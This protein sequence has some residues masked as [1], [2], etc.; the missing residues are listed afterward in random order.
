MRIGRILKIVL[1]VVPVALV[2]GIAGIVVILSGTDFNQ[3]KP[4]IAEETK[5]AI[6]RDLVIAGDL[7]L[8]ISLSP[9]VAVS[10]LTLSNAVWSERRDM[11]AI[12]RLEAQVALLP[13]LFGDIEVKRVVLI[14]AD[15]A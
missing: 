12:E 8:E 9:A 3:Y 2:A 5:K 10:G 7:K 14:G 6:G 13:L 1:V 11:V 15:I 4:L